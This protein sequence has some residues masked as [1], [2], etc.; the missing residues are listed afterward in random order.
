MLSRSPM[1]R[2]SITGFSLL[3][4][5]VATVVIAIVITPLFGSLQSGHQ[6]SARILEET[7][8]A[9]AGTSLLEALAAIPFSRLP[10]IP[11]D[12]QEVALAPCFA[13]PGDVPVVAPPP[14]GF[15]RSVTVKY[16]FKKSIDPAQ[17]SKWG[18]QKLLTVKVSWKPDSLNGL[19][20]RFLIFSTLVTDDLEGA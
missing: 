2:R 4:I 12:T 13:D 20:T 6:Q 18:N 16:I 3:E 8:A 11:D 19:T 9:N 17:D 15:T 14:P 5:L 7:L 1:S 10:D